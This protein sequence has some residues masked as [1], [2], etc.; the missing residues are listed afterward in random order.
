[1]NTLFSGDIIEPNT[2]IAISAHCIRVPVSDGHLATVSIRYENK[3]SKE[4]LLDV[5][6]SYKGSLG[7]I[8]LPSL[9]ESFLTY[10]EEEDRPA[11][12]TDRMIYN[13][14]GVSCGRIREDSIFDYKM[15]TL[16]HNTIRGAAG[17]AVLIAELLAYK[18]Y[19]D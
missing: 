3:P 13:G 8:K 12:G 2:E 5:I 11:T 17:G 15:V 7:D 19:F 6:K 10:F 9:P 14:M 18:G 4:K 1:M 16:S